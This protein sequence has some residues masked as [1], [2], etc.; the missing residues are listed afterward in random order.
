MTELYKAKIEKKIELPL[1]EFPVSAGFPS[2]AEDFVDKHLD[3]NEYIVRHPA[4]TFFVRVKGYSMQGCGITDGDLVVVDRALDPGDKSVVVAF[5]NGEFTMKRVR[6][7]KGDLYL[8]PENESYEPIKVTE[9]MD[10]QVWG[11]VTH[12]IKEIR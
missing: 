8:V 2:P 10:F 3:L 12:A 4:A 7:K 6:F 1:Y 11:V 5:L 9:E